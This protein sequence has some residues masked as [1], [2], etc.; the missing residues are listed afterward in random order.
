M[1]GRRHSEETKQKISKSKR[2]NPSQYWLGKHRSDETKEKLRAANLGKRLTDEQKAIFAEK[3][4]ETRNKNGTDKLSWVSIQQFSLDGVLIH[5]WAKLTDASEALNV[6]PGNITK[7]CR[8]LRKSAGGFRWQ[9]ADP[10]HL[11]QTAEND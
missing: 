10:N 1:H 9:Y 2:E 11:Q 7:V 6:A 5:T 3:C 4:N 8:G